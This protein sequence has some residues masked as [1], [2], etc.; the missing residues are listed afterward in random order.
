MTGD[1]WL[2]CFRGGGGGGKGRIQAARL[3]AVA[4]LAGAGAGGA[5][6]LGE[7]LPCRGSP[8]A[9]KQLGLR[10]TPAPNTHPPARR[11]GLG[12]ARAAGLVGHTHT[13]TPPPPY[14]RV[15]RDGVLHGGRCGAAGGWWEPADPR[16]GG[17]PQ[18]VGC[19]EQVGWLPGPE[20]GLPKHLGVFCAPST[21]RLAAACASHPCLLRALRCHG[22]RGARLSSPPRAIAR[23]HQWRGKKP[24]SQLG[25]VGAAR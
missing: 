2:G 15:P 12:A 4:F 18:V 8:P 16:C 10:R 24:R 22:E 21:R 13:H 7:G 14:P 3:A 1:S 5:R 6:P 25:T 20:R 11:H 17:E 9:S 19:P 23:L